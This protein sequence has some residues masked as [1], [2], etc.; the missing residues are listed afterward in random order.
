MF[1]F[2]FF[3]YLFNF[4][5]GYVF[6]VWFALTFL[7][8]LDLGCLKLFGQLNCIFKLQAELSSMFFFYNI[9]PLNY[10]SS[11]CAKIFLGYE[12][13]PHL[14]YLV[15]S[16]SSAFQTEHAET[17]RNTHFFTLYSLKIVK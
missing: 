10:P 11:D 14:E 17:L 7:F 13:P 4:Y 8:F 1:F 9:D 15:Q 3:K 6:L 12:N 2:S 16:K 5:F